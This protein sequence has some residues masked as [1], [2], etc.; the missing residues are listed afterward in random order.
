V[1]A[2]RSRVPCAGTR[3]EGPLRPIPLAVLLFGDA[4]GAYA[5]RLARRSVE[6]ALGVS[7]SGTARPSGTDI[8]PPSF[9]ERRGVFVTWKRYPDGRLR[10]C[11]GF[12]LPVL[13]LERAIR[14]AAV[15]AA[16]EDPRFPPVRAAELPQLTVEVSALTVPQPLQ[17]R[18]PADAIRAI[19]VGRDGLIVE[20]RG[21]SGLLLPQVAPE[22][23]WSAEEL[24][25]GT[26]EK[27]GLPPGAWRDP[28]VR[29]RRFEAEVFVEQRPGGEVV[30][31]PLIHRSAGEP[32]AR[33]T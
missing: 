25:E 7:P 23:G 6:E 8:A 24:L 4:E 13:P 30:R 10:G 21:T 26:C 2:R 22:Q 29:V 9:A 1:A 5:V 33:R 19:Q 18:T 16:V 20:G 15:A 27:A 32:P 11:I 31:E 12:P 3:G 17:F 28:S 14:E